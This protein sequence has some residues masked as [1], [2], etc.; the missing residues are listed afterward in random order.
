MAKGKNQYVVPTKNGWGVK[1]EGNSKLTVKTDT[2]VDA[3]KIGKEI[4]K[5]QQSELTILGKDGKIQNKN[6]YG[7]DPFPAKDTIH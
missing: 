3:L 5:N 7:N 6:S 2:K 1:G 4:A